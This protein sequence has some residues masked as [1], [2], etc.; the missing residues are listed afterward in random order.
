M[1]ALLFDRKF[2]ALLA[3]V[4]SGISL[5][6]WL[7][8]RTTEEDYQPL[9][10]NLDPSDANHIV[11]QLEKEKIPHVLSQN[12]QSLLVP[13][14]KVLRLRMQF[15][16]EG[17][18][19][20]TGVGFEIFDNKSIGMTEFTQK[21]NYQ[22]AL[23]GELARTINSIDS[24]QK[25][26]VHI[27]LP[28]KSLFMEEETKPTASIILSLKPGRALSEA[29]V[30]GITHLVASSIEGLE[31]EGISIIDQKGA[32]LN[33]SGGGDFNKLNASMLEYQKNLEKS[34]ETKITQLLSQV[35]GSG[36]VTAKV[37][38]DVDYEQ[39]EKTE[40]RY[41]PDSA[42]V[43]AEQRTTEKFEGNRY[44]PTGVPGSANLPGQEN[45]QTAGNNSD[46]LNEKIDYEINKETKR[47]T[48]PYGKV[49]KLTVAVM[50][51]VNRTV[52]GP[53]STLEK[54]T[55]EELKELEQLVQT[56]IGY[57][58]TRGDEVVVREKPFKVTD[59]SDADEYLEKMR[60]QAMIFYFAKIGGLLLIAILSLLFIVVPIIRW[61]TQNIS[62]KREEVSMA[63]EVLDEAKSSQ[64]SIEDKK[65]VIKE[66]AMQDPE[67]MV[68]QLRGW[69][70]T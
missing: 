11:S 49:K 44:Q 50:V 46:R 41:D 15:A 6:S 42:V 17:V 54:R 12:G 35:V 33:R 28:E 4:A 66:L 10:T 39:I 67:K 48:K 43:K 36:K 16:S 5:V 8:F 59:Y 58:K 24:V 27:V 40:E 22:R 51:D 13:P 21:L 62:L 1:T 34:Y 29:Q 23:Q 60:Q 55:D 32:M 45:R 53:E 19:Q 57:D 70:T 38:A 68:Q 37:A 20:G 3:I 14:D 26:R 47:T 31:P 64:K 2:Y 18:P 25:S 69:L 7:A 56:A 61:L 65:R 9:F 30:M 52:K 63:E